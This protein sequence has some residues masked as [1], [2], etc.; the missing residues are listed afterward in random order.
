M[1]DQEL[2]K[3]LIEPNSTKL[4]LVVLDGVGGLPVNGAS[5]LEKADAPNL[6]L[7]ANSSACGLQVPVAYGITPGSGPGHLGIFGYNPLQYEIGRGVLEGLGLGIHLTEN[8]IAIRCNYATAAHEGSKIIIKDRRAGRIPTDQSKK[9]TG[10]LQE[11]IKQIEDAQII[12]LPG[13]EHR[14]A[15]VLRFQHALEKG[16]DLIE[17]TDP[18]KE[19]LEPV[20]PSPSSKQAKH[21]AEI[22]L[23]FVEKAAQ[24][25]KD[26]EKANYILLRGFSSVPKIPKFNEVYGMKS[27]AIATYPMYLGVAKL[28]GMDTIKPEGGIAQEIEALKNNYD[29]YDFFY[30]HVKKTDSNGEDGNFDGKCKVIEEFDK[31][32]PDI[33]SLNP[34]V[35]VITGDHS[36]PALIKGH[37]WHPVPVLLKSRYVFG[38]TSASFTERECLKGELGIFHSTDIIPLM[39]ANGMRLKKFGA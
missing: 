8:D 33:L 21:V 1:N 35:L 19:G 30:L 6:S 24:I 34:D 23:K 31:N 38:R 36:T 17:D 13:M 11:Q 26:Q 14:F 20:V 37:S 18:Q 12:L 29:K 4:I 39:L 32:L 5:E 15:L 10:I 16:A 9:I 3:P 22:A 2:L 25:L 27:V 7:L 28:L